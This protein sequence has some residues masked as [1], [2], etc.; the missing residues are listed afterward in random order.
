M[1]PLELCTAFVLVHGE[2]QRLSGVV[3]VDGKD[4][5]TGWQLT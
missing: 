5:Q 3:C 2:L 4:W 1:C